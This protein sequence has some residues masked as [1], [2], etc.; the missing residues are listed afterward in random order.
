MFYF[1]LSV[2]VDFAKKKNILFIVMMRSSDK[3]YVD[4]KV[5]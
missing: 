1:E 2:G 5:F 3:S 4:M